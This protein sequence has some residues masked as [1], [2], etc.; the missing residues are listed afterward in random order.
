[1]AHRFSILT[2]TGLLAAAAVLYAGDPKCN[3]A[4]RECDQQI[5]NMLSGKR[6]LGATVEERRPGLVIKTV[7][8]KSP[9]WRAGLRAGDRLIAANGR[10]VTHATARDF[11]QIIADARVTGRVDMIIWR[12]GAY[13]KVLL[14]LEPYTKEQMDKIIAGHLAAHSTTSTGSH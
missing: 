2:V 11:K 8:D 10:S 13:S 6:Y 9:A 12:G 14:R 1:M 4:A 5:R 3:V 7:T